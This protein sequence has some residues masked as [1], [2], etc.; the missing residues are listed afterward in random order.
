MTGQNDDPYPTRSSLLR[1]IKDPQD[2][3]SWQEFYDVYS[4]L[5]FSFAL[6]A[7]LT[8][9][10]SEEVVQETMIAAAK[11]LPEFR[12][13]PKVCSFK[14]WLLNLSRWRVVDQLRKR[15]TPWSPGVGSAHAAADDSS[16]TGTIESVPDPSG[17]RLEAIWD[18]EWRT[19]LLDAALARVKGRVDARHWQIFEACALKEWPVKEV[20][21]AFGV[22]AG[23]VYL[24]KHRVS[25]LLKKERKRLERT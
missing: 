19:T 7:G 1:R 25:V 5:V 8:K 3:R 4:K 23:R 6:K 20:A 14:T 2:E 16:R 22:S 10:E 13:D 21:Q 17:E 15:R 11:H 12:Y 24:T 9:D 18:E